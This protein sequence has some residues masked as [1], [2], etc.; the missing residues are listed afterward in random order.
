MLAVLICVGGIIAL[1]LFG[2]PVAFAFWGAGLVLMLATGTEPMFFLPYGFALTMG[3]S[4][5]AL[6]LFIALGGVVGE[7]K[8]ADVLLGFVESQLR[9]FKSY[10]GAVTI[11]TCALFGSISG[12]STSAIATIGRLMIPRMVAAGYPRGHATGL[13]ACSSMLTLLIPPSVTM[14]VF[15]LMAH[16]SVAACWAA[17]VVPGILITILYVIIN[18]RVIKNVPTVKLLPPIS[19]REQHRQV[20]KSTRRAI[21][22][23]LMPI[24]LLGGIYGGI[25]TPT[26]G[27]S[28]AVVYALV[29]GFFVYRGLTIR[30]TLSSFRASAAITGS[31]IIV[32]YFLFCFS[33]LMVQMRVTDR[34]IELIVTIA[35]NKYVVLLLLNLL[36]LII[37]MIMDDISGAI[38]VAV[39]CMPIVGTFGLDPIHFAAL[40]GVV[41][42]LGNVTPPVAPMLYM[43]G[44]I[45]GDLPLNEY[46]WPT[47]RFAIF[48]HLPV[49][50]LVTFLPI[51]ATWLPSLLGLTTAVYYL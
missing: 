15:A 45:G 20:M 24:V 21:P 28:V 31:I 5:L 50:L 19:F 14:I 35:T 8:I 34:L 10:V 13:V 18:A 42:G 30:N 16:L 41:L 2:V 46:L 1:M 51:L 39:I 9:R 7:A 43:A 27:G 38:V 33:Q 11:V 49:I 47:M 32:L 3:F 36:I 22:A 40:E 48:G 12:S 44:K 29:V 37:G 6:P 23:L 26:E 4:L 17:T 25:W